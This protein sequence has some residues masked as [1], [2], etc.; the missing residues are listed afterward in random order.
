MPK[1]SSEDSKDFLCNIEGCSKSYTTLFALRRHHLSHE[2][3]RPYPCNYKE[4][5]LAFYTKQHLERHLKTHCKE[6]KFIC[7]WQGKD[8]QI[9][10]V[11]KRDKS[12]II[13]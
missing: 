3:K 10:R 6:R 7:D 5:S 2:N 8:N 13:I 1:S 11:M 12:L 4:C 9:Y